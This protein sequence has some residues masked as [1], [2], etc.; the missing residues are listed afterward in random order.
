M[1]P[2]PRTETPSLKELAENA[3]EA[4]ENLDEARFRKTMNEIDRSF[5]P[6]LIGWSAGVLFM[7]NL[8]RIAKGGEVRKASETFKQADR[9]AAKLGLEKIGESLGE[10]LDHNKDA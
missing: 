10:I 7:G 5:M 4:A 9:M 6:G 8:N 3:C 2:K 1:K